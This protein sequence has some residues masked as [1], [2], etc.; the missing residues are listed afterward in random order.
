MK[1]QPSASPASYALGFAT[2]HLCCYFKHGATP[3]SSEEKW[4]AAQS[5][6]GENWR[7]GI[8]T[9]DNRDILELL[10]DELVFNRI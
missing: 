6:F 5:S 9:K 3:N 2:R 4:L 1:P 8:M 7:I 10:K